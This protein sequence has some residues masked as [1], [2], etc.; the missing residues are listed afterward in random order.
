MCDEGS[1]FFFC[2]SRALRIAV[3]FSSLLIHPSPRQIKENFGVGDVSGSI[4]DVHATSISIGALGVSIG[5]DRLQVHASGVSLAASG[6]SALDVTIVF[7]H[8]HCNGPVTITASDSTLD[9]SVALAADAAG[10][11]QLS[12]PDHVSVSLNHLDVKFGCGGFDGGL[13]NDIIRVFSSL[14]QS[15][16]QDTAQGLVDGAVADAQKLLDA[17]PLSLPLPLPPPFNNT[18]LRAGIVGQPEWDAGTSVSLC[19]QGDAAPT[20]WPAGTP[21]PIS[22]PVL[23]NASSTDRFVSIL[24]SQYSVA[25]LV[26]ALFQSSPRG[27]VLTPNLIPLGLN[28]TAGWALFAPGLPA[29]YPNASVGAALSV[30]GSPVASLNG[31]GIT[32][33][34]LASVTADLRVAIDVY[35]AGAS[36]PS[37]PGVIVIGVNVSFVA[38]LGW[39]PTG[40]VPPGP[41]A[42]T[43]FSASFHNVSDTAS[44]VSSSVGPVPDVS[45]IAELVAGAINALLPYVNAATAGGFEVA[46]KG[47]FALSDTSFLQTTDYLQISSDLLL[48]PFT[49]PQGGVRA[50]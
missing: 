45:L 10:R 42:V 19:V 18:A 32:G 3:S 38:D 39:Q 6:T 11:A 40:G 4:N 21:L 8:S 48:G 12:V 35:A 27:L 24:V 49:P 16:I 30:I 9:F 31:S 46:I 36:V 17:L 15:A 7:V 37:A 1:S 23:P 41:T 29:A 34:G 28:T 26:W 25:S 44:L 14:L 22:P 2:L 33:A 47:L 50:S 5:A 13:I 43:N 20:S